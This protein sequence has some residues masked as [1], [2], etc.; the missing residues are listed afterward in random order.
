MRNSSSAGSSSRACAVRD[1][2]A[3]RLRRTVTHDPA[4]PFLLSLLATMPH[5]ASRAERMAL[6]SVR[7]FAK[8][9]SLE[10]DF[11]SSG[12]ARSPTGARS[13]PAARALRAGPMDPSSAV[14]VSSE[15]LARAPSVLIPMRARR[16]SVAGPTPLMALTGSGA[17]NAASLP[18]RT[19]VSPR[20]F[21]ASDATLA[22]L[23]HTPR[24][25]EQ[26]T[27][28]SATRAWILRQMLTG[29]SLE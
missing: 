26:L 19:T 14:R 28:S 20:G 21:S 13:V 29:L 6:S 18:G 24:P 3:S 4:S 27:P 5:V 8:V 15:A 9:R 2:Q 12:F 7:S 17:R 1:V 23:L 10:T 25:M 22:T 16:A 11:A